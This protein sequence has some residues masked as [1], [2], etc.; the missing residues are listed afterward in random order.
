MSWD[1]NESLLRR[2]VCQ[3]LS[4]QESRNLGISVIRMFAVLIM[5]LPSPEDMKAVSVFI[6]PY[7]VLKKFD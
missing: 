6:G 2:R 1:V 7:K 4:P 5:L 3:S